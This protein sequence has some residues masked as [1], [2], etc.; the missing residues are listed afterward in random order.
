MK[1]QPAVRKQSLEITRFSCG[2]SCFV[3]KK[4]R[5]YWKRRAN[6][7]QRR[8]FQAIMRRLAHD[9]EEFFDEPF[10]VPS[11]DSWDLW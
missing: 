4:A 11:L 1:T 7:D 10:D 8:C 9:H 3:R 5:R 6:R 2:G